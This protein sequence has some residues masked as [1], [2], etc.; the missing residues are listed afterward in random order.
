MNNHSHA[1]HVGSHPG[2]HPVHPTHPADNAIAD[3]A[4]TRGRF[5]RTRPGIIMWLLWLLYAALGAERLAT[6]LL[7]NIPNT[8]LLLVWKVGASISGPIIAA[9]AIFYTALPLRGGR[10]L[11]PASADG[12][13]ASS[14]AALVFLLIVRQ[15]F[16]LITIYPNINSQEQLVG[17]IAGVVL[18][19]LIGMS[20]GCAISAAVNR[21][22]D[23]DGKTRGNPAENNVAQQPF[24]NPV[25]F[26]KD[27]R[28]GHAAIVLL[29][30]F[31]VIQVASMYTRVFL[32]F[33][34]LIS[35]VFGLLFCWVLQRTRYFSYV[36]GFLGLVGLSANAYVLASAA[37]NEP[38]IFIQG[39]L[40]PLEV[41]GLWAGIAALF[42]ATPRGRAALTP[43]RPAGAS[44]GKDLVQGPPAFGAYYSH[45]AGMVV[46]GLA[47]LALTPLVWGMAVL[48][49]APE[50]AFIQMEAMVFI[51]PSVAGCASLIWLGYRTA[52][53]RK[54]MGLPVYHV[55]WVF[56]LIGI[57]LTFVQGFFD[58]AI[59]G[60]ADGGSV[61]D[62]MAWANVGLLALKSFFYAGF[63]AAIVNLIF[64]VGK[65]RAARG[66]AGK[67]TGN[68]A[69]KP[70]D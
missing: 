20:V 69:E 14:L 1:D 11:G 3:Q 70:A 28:R 49:A 58:D 45:T 22:T 56:V 25:A 61:G 12:W 53:G 18:H 6:Y 40:E 21:V 8:P 62:P 41:A 17:I 24:L 59:S 55:V 65:V 47:V 57:G 33:P 23:G 37:S 38:T 48:G 63:V 36:L 30:I 51:V 7:G 68:A 35:A 42:P 2:T 19:I 29:L 4:L 50:R 34:P 15:F 54:L 43:E 16:S 66:S 13:L 5:F 64:P 32:V 46:A 60:S 27:T 52:G 44:A 9:V 10:K 26:I 31:V 39:L 67:P